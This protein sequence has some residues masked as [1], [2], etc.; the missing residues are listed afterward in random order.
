MV[1][2][3]TKMHIGHDRKSNEFSDL[4][5]VDDFMDAALAGFEIL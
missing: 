2:G 3:D 4:G 5:N 1:S